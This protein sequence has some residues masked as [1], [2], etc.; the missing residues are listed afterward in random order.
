[1]TLCTLDSRGS[2]ELVRKPESCD[3][4]DHTFYLYMARFY[5]EKGDPTRA[6][7][8]MGRAIDYQLFP[9]P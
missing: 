6:N 9:P 2:G 4:Q 8:A 3:T 5:E 7:R 1:M